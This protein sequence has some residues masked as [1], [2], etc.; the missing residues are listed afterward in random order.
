MVHDAA[1]VLF[2]LACP[3]CGAPAEPVCAACVEG[4]RPAPPLGVP[5]G[6]D[7]LSVAFAYEG[8]VREI[9]ARVK[10][11]G[12][13]AAVPWLAAAMVAALVPPARLDAV[14]WAP[15]TASRRRARGFDHA[16]LL[17]RAVAA[18]LHLPCR[19]L[20]VRGGGPAQT[21]ASRSERGTR[22]AFAGRR[23]AAGRRVLVV[24]DVLTTGATMRAA[25]RAL[26]AR[27]AAG[28]DALVAARTP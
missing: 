28:V 22:P 13:R 26:R 2:P 4:L 12:V 9:V 1:R 3:G 11:R 15:T 10:Y 24:D 6:L 20:L 16:Q 27:G 19:A 7:S 8:V 17:A 21:G 23:G 18:E 14:T 25:A 5:A